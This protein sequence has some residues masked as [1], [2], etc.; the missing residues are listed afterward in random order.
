MEEIIVEGA[1]VYIHH[2]YM[3]YYFA[4]SVCILEYSA[5][6]KALF[7]CV[8]SF[9]AHFIILLCSVWLNINVTWTQAFLIFSMFVINFNFELQCLM[10]MYI[11]L[12]KQRI[13]LGFAK[14]VRHSHNMGKH[15]WC[16]VCCKSTKFDILL[17]LA[18]LAFGQILNRIIEGKT[19][20]Y[21][22]QKVVIPPD[23]IAAKY[24]WFTSI[25]F[26]LT[27][28]FSCWLLCNIKGKGKLG[29]L[30]FLVD[31]CPMVAAEVLQTLEHIIM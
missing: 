19:S 25:E 13:S 14:F 21:I 29:V 1:S 18:F 17:N 28:I 15:L 10:Y 24:R 8:L 9:F 16:P 11:V 5:K 23:F 31:K 20:I 7:E 2:M 3:Y 27:I 22:S 26:W 4:L 12:R 30:S 6:P